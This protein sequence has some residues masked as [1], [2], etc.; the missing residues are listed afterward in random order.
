[1]S[2]A[3]F[4]TVLEELRDAAPPAPERL[5]ALV[6]TLPAAQPRLTLRLRP[7][8]SAA[9]VIATAVGVGAAI[10][11]GLSGTAGH[12]NVANYANGPAPS[13]KRGLPANAQKPL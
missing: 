7:A 2:E 5:R 11:G 10:I 9:I 8:L 13:A 4:E 12:G 3:S 6:H 1:M